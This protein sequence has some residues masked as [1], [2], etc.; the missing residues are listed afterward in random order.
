M[1]AKLAVIA[2]LCVRCGHWTLALSIYA[3]LRCHGVEVEAHFEA[4][5]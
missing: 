3:L 1:A 4:Q 2:A 5:K